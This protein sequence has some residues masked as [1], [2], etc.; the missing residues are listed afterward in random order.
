MTRKKW[1]SKRKPHRREKGQ[2]NDLS[3]IMAWCSLEAAA[4]LVVVVTLYMNQKQKFSYLRPA[5]R[6]QKE[7]SLHRRA[8]FVAEKEK[9][10]RRKRMHNLSGAKSGSI[11][12]FFTKK[13][14]SVQI[15]RSPALQSVRLWVNVFA[16][17]S[18]SLWRRTSTVVLIVVD[19]VEAVQIRK[20]FQE[21][22][23]FIVAIIVMIVICWLVACFSLALLA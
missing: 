9:N 21:L 23:K 10:G 20:F 12:F 16:E 22:G 5:K 19:E 2:M 15:N 4:L 13:L 1:M 11:A 3:S 14:E 8:A 7:S 6:N 18:F 17:C